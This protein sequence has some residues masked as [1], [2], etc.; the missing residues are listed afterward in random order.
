MTSP[1]KAAL[2]HAALGLNYVGL[3]QPGYKLAPELAEQAKLPH[4]GADDERVVVTV[5]TWSGEKA[6]DVAAAAVALGAAV[7][8]QAE[9]PLGGVVR[10][11]VAPQALAALAQQNAVAWIEPWVAPKLHNDVARTIMHVDQVQP[12]LG[13]YGDGQ[14]AAVAD[15][16]LDTG[17]AATVHPDFRS[18]LRAAFAWGRPTDPNS[19]GDPG[20]DWS[21]QDGHGTHVAGSVLGDG[22]MSG[23]T[24]ALKS[25]CWLARRRCAA[26]AAGLSIDR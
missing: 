22:T 19:P 8:S 18:H 16:G 10:L 9:N 15:S 12:G 14:I 1:T 25:V 7:Q 13:L 21:D 20:G 24:P 26:C 6:A 5:T 17:S 23:A 3:I 2:D 4:A 11:A